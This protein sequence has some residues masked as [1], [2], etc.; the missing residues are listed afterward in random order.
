MS[1]PADQPPARGRTVLARF[2][3]V[4][5]AL[6]CVFPVVYYGMRWPEPQTIPAPERQPR[7]QAI[8]E[9][10]LKLRPLQVPIRPPGLDDW[11]ANHKESGQTFDEYLACEPVTLAGRRRIIYIQPL[12]DFAPTQRTIVTLTAEFMAAYFNTTVKVSDDLPLALIPSQHRRA[13]SGRKCA[14]PTYSAASSSP[15]CKRTPRPASR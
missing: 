1:A 4:L 14:R 5:A 3:W 8:R 11:L 10:M 7:E 2:L 9:M 13:A 15:A 6:A 12:G